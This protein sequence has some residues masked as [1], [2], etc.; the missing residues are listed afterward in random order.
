MAKEKSD[1]LKITKQEEDYSR[2]YLDIV[3]RAK[4]AEESGVRGCMII[5]PEGFAIWENMQQTLDKMFKDTGHS[6]AYFPLFI[7]VSYFSKEAKH[8]SGFAKECAVV[9]HHR[10]TTNESGEIVVDP[11]AELGEPLVVR[12]TSETIIWSAYRKW[13]Q[14]YR[15][16]PILLNQWVNVCRWELRTRPF[17]R[18]TEFLWQEGHTAHATFE[19]AEAESQ[20]MLEVYKTFVQD[21]LAIPVLAG[22]KT[23]NEKFPGAE[24]TYTIETMTQ[25]KRAIQVATSHNLGTTFAKAF[26]VTYLSAEGTQEYPFATSWGITTRLIGTLIMVHSDNQGFVCPPK[27]A[28]LQVIGV[29]I[30]RKEAEKENVLAKFQ[31]LQDEFKTLDKFSFKVD[32]RENLSPGFKFNDW[33]L[34]GIP[35]RMEMGPR[36]LQNGNV[37]LVRRDTG[38]KI[39]VPQS[40]LKSKIPELLE[41]IQTSLFQKA[42]EFQRQNT[43]SVS[44]Y[45]EFKAGIE[46][47]PGFYLAYFDG[48]PE[49]EETIQEETKATGRC[50]PLGENSKPGKCFYTGKQTSQQVIFARAY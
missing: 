7:P 22:R 46:T 3:D 5:R 23:E 10:L 42:Q 33:E 16:L 2:W 30:F 17:L 15:D 24:H 13:I 18:T 26:D 50:I 47:K 32:V 6:N 37:V 11:E 19:E 8:V 38:E 43:Y 40:E 9:T 36:D 45:E 41:D 29:P 39:I 4:L 1:L 48:S 27:I 35:L 34:K 21:Y 25:D 28:P 44:T 49:D 31:E 14:S 12:P 20:Q